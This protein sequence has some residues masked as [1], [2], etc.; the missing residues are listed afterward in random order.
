[1]SESQGAACLIDIIRSLPV[2]G[3]RG[4]NMVKRIINTHVFERHSFATMISRG[5]IFHLVDTPNSAQRCQAYLALKL[6]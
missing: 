6:H 3:R 4:R 1:M 2:A 5:G